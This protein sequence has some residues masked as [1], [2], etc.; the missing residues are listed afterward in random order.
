MTNKEIYNVYE[1]LCEISQDKTLKFN[2]KVSY[3]FA[4]TKNLLEP[5]YKAIVETRSAIL[6]QYGEVTAEGWHIPKDKIELFNTEWD[7][8]MATENFFN[9]EKVLLKDL[10]T[11]QI[12]VEL[13][14]KLL[15]LINN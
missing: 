11:T 3:I 1:G 7:S 8:F 14:E 10:E 9:A 12:S 4:K 6:K 15:P 5:Y 13:M 2:V